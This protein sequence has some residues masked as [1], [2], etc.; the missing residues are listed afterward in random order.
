MSITVVTDYSTRVELE[1]TIGML[2]DAA[3]DISRRGKIGTLSDEYRIRH[4]RI[5]AVLATWET[6]PDA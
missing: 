4:E 5:N 6:T 1:R 2:N 3:K